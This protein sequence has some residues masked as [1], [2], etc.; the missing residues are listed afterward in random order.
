MFGFGNKNSSDFEDFRKFFFEYSKG[1][2]NSLSKKYKSYK[3]SRFFAFCNDDYI[4]ICISDFL[5]LDTEPMDSE[6]ELDLYYYLEQ[7]FKSNSLS[8]FTPYELRLLGDSDDTHYLVFQF[9]NLINLEAGDT[10]EGIEESTDVIK[11]LVGPD[12]ECNFEIVTSATE[13]SNVIDRVPVILDLFKVRM[14]RNWSNEDGIK[15]SGIA[16]ENQQCLV[17]K[18][19]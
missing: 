5:R 14:N 15:L 18:K 16:K 12:G 10:V 7:E 19:R 2:V 4:T 6:L 11:V 13:G 17:R 1:Q 8:L 9:L 3:P